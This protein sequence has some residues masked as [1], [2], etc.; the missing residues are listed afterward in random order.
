MPHSPVPFR[1]ILNTLEFIKFSHTVFALPFALMAMWVAA[2]GWPSWRTAG[3]IVLCMA[4]ARTAAMAFNRFID[5]EYDVRNPRTQIRSTLATKATALWL[6]LGAIVVFKTACWF[7]NPLCF[8]LSPVAA[9]IVLGYSLTKRFTAFSH[10]FLGLALAVAPMGAWA[11]VTGELRSP[12]PYVL[13]AAVW[14]WVFGFDL[15][16]ATQDVD[17]DREAG[18]FS[19]PARF[20]IPATLLL[21]RVLHGMTWLILAGFGLLAGLGLSYWICLGL[22]AGAL[23]VEHGLGGSGDLRKINAAFFQINALV[24][25][26]MLVGTYYGLEKS[27]PQEAEIRLRPMPVPRSKN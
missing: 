7:I 5:W 24:G 16:Y 2:G 20:G 17:F 11:A 23:V 8:W 3:L 21:A 18:L 15:I 12:E 14:A 19:F 10:A 9:G 27:P 25:L 4:S 1:K 6:C 22:V 26:L 13:A